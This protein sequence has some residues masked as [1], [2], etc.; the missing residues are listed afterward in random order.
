MNSN[1]Y[2]TLNEIKELYETNNEYKN[3]VNENIDFICRT[4]KHKCIEMTK[5]IENDLKREY[6]E[7]FNIETDIIDISVD[8]ATCKKIEE[9]LCKKIESIDLDHNIIISIFNLNK[10]GYYQSRLNEIK[11]VI[12]R[13]SANNRIYLE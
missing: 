13:S 1:N 5:D 8:L 2:L 11:Q 3:K 9:L 7:K 6:K 4:T 12:S 10:Y